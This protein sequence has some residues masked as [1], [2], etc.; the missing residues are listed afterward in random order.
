MIGLTRD[1][2][3]EPVLGGKILRRERRQ[4]KVDF[5]FSADHEQDWHLYRLMPDLLYVMTIPSGGKVPQRLLVV[6]NILMAV[7]IAMNTL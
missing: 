2:T 1:G 4:G 6:G 5:R 3:T 7:K